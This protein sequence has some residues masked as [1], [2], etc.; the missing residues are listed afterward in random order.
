M[1]ELGNLHP[2]SCWASLGVPGR[3]RHVLADVL[4]PAVA[5]LRFLG[6]LDA[7][8][9]VAAVAVALEVPALVSVDFGRFYL[10]LLD[11]GHRGHR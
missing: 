5:S 3:H 8:G 1:K 11:R 7:L 9:G 2:L 6:R 10:F 4:G